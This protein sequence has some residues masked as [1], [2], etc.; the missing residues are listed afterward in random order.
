M[1]KKNDTPSVRRSDVAALVEYFGLDETDI[2]DRLTGET[3]KESQYQVLAR[4]VS[5]DAKKSV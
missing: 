3:T 1:K 4:E 5:M 2:R